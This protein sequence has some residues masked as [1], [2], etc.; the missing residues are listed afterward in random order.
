MA[1][2]Q[3]KLFG[4]IQLTNFA[5]IYI[6][7]QINGVQG[8]SLGKSANAQVN[9][10]PAFI[11]EANSIIQGN[12]SEDNCANS[13]STYYTSKLGESLDGALIFENASGFAQQS[14]ASQ[15][16]RLDDGTKTRYFM[17]NFSRNGYYN[18]GYFD[19]ISGYYNLQNVGDCR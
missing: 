6:D 15:Y 1:A 5:N 12:T 19:S 10:S 13:A 18:L 2:G 7:A 14:L 4:T 9:G 11:T 3:V 17:G 16:F 8:D